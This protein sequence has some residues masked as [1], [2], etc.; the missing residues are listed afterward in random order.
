MG[1][2]IRSFPWSRTALGPVTSWPQSLKIAL[3]IMLGSRYQMFVWWGDEL[4]K[5]YNDAYISALGQRHPWALGQPASTVWSEIWG[6]IGPQTETVL[7]ENRATW[8]DRVEL[9]ME[10]NGYMEETF[11]TFSYSPL[12]ND[13]GEIG[14]VFC[15]CSEETERVLG[16]RRLATLRQLGDETIRAQNVPEACELAAKALEKNARDVSFALIYLLEPDGTT[17]RLVANT[18]NIVAGSA[19]APKRVD[20]RDPLA[21][22]AWPF[23]RALQGERVKVSELT[24]QCGPLPGGEWP[25]PTHTAMVLPL[26]RGAQEKPGGFVILGAS[27]R[28]GF[29]D[30]YQ[31]FMEL[32]AAAIA[33]AVA[34]ARAYDDERRRAESL[35]ELDRAKTAF[36][37]NVSHEF[38]TP[39]TLMLGPLED[40]L[41]R[42]GE[43]PQSAERGELRVVH[44]NGLRLLKL[45]NT[46]LDF[47]QIEAGRMQ[48]T[49]VET[50]LAVL[51]ADLASVFRSAMEKAGLNFTIDCP[52]LPEPV[53]VDPDMW[54]KIVFNLLSNALKFTLDGDV[55]LTLS[56]SPEAAVLS[57]SDTGLGI[58]PEELPNLFKRFHRIEST[59][60]RTHEGTGIGLALVHDLAKLH[61]GTV[62]VENGDGG[63]GT[64]FKVR[65]PFGKRHLPPER[66]GYERSRIH[67]ARHSEEFIEEASTWS[68]EE[69]A[70]GI[71]V[72]TDTSEHPAA[73]SPTAVRPRVLLA[74]DNADMR[75]YVARL[76]GTRYRV[77]PVADGVTALAAARRDPPDLILSDVMMPALDGFALVKELRADE[78]LKS[79]P[80]ILLSA[81]AGEEARV[82]G[83]IAGADDYVTKPFTSR[84][85]LARVATQL[86]LARVRREAALQVQRS[87]RFVEKIA[88]A[89]PDILFAYDLVEQRN[90][91]I[92]RSVEAV[93]GYS[94][95]QVQGMTNPGEQLVHPD[96][97]AARADYLAGFNQ[98]ADGAVR[99]F[100]YRLRAVNGEDRWILTRASVFARTAE[101]RP[102]E[103]I[104]VAIDITARKRTETALRESEDRYRAVLDNQTEML[105]RFHRDGTI[106]FVNG[107]Y[108]RS[109]GAGR[110]EL[111]GKNLWKFIPE[112]DHPAI[113]AMLDGLTAAAPEVQIENRFETI[114]G[115][116]WTLWTNRAVSFDST[117]RWKEA[118]STGIDITDRKQSEIRLRASEDQARA[119]FSELS[120]LYGAAPVGLAL[121]DRDLRFVR[122]NET[123][124]GI[125]GVPVA[126]T[127][128]RTIGEIVPGVADRIERAY[129]Q[130][131]ETGEP[132]KYDLEGEM[133][134]SP[135][136]RRHFLV[137]HYPLQQ[138]DGSVHGIGCV[139]LETTEQKRAEAIVR[140]SE[141]RQSFLLKL[142]DAL[143]PLTNPV[144]IQAMA[145]QVLGEHLAAS[146]V[147]YFEV[148]DTDYILARN[149]T[150]GVPPLIGA[151]PIA[152]FGARLLTTYR[153]GRTVSCCNVA[154][155]TELTPAERAAY[156]A[157]QI[158]AHIGV[159]LVKGG[160]LVAGFAV[161][162]SGPREWKRWEIALTEETAQRTWAAVERARAEAALHDSEARL[163]LATEAANIYSWEIDLAE[164]H[165]MWGTNAPTV[166]GFPANALTESVDDFVALVHPDD[167]AA[168]RQ[169]VKS[170][171]AAGK[172]FAAEF[173]LIHPQTGE[174]VWVASQAAA[175]HEAPGNAGLARYFGISQNITERKRRET[176]LAFLAEIDA[177]LARHSTAE[178]ILQTVGR[179]IGEFLRLSSCAFCEVDGARAENRLQYLWQ[180]TDPRDSVGGVCCQ[181][182]YVSDEFLRA[183]LSGERVVV[184]DT[185][186]DSRVAH[187]TAYDAIQ[188]RSF[189]TVPFLRDGARKYL[190][191]VTDSAPRQ[192]RGDELDVITELC[193][194]IFPRLERA[195]AEAALRTSEARF[196]AAAS[197]VSSLIWTNNARGEMEGE[198]PGWTGFTGQPQE[199]LQGYGWAKAVHPDDAQPTI[200]AWKR[201]VEEKRMFEFEHRLWRKDGEW[202][203]CTLR[204]VPV[205][206]EAGKICEWVGVH[207]D[208]TPRKEAEKKVRESEARLR[209]SLAACQIGAWDF[210]L[211]AHTA[212][213]SLEHDRIFGYEQLLSAWTLDDFFQ[214]ALPEYHESVRQMVAEATI[215]RTGFTCEC[216]IRRKDG[217]IRWIWFSGRHFVDE[218]G[219][220]RV[221]G[222][223][224]DI[225]ERK[226]A[227]AALREAHEL[228]TDKAAQLESLVQQR[229]TK[230]REMVGELEAFSYSIAHDMRA[231]LRSL[232]GFSDVLLTEHAGN[233]DPEAQ[234]FLR[235][236]ANSAGRMDKLIQDVLN[237]SRIVRAELPLESVD[238]EKL[239]R[240]I[241]DTYPMFLPEKVEI[242]IE[243]TFS[244]VLGNEAML[245][246][247]FSNLMGNAAKF[248][249]PGVKPRIRVWA[250]PDPQRVR[251]FIQDNGIG[252]APEQ[253]EKIF[254]I[255]QQGNK[256][257]EGTGIG[258]AIVKKAVER[259]SGQIGI[260]S[261]P[262]SGSTFWFEIQ[263]A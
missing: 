98:A 69:N 254:G 216:R 218:T 166:L 136:I 99:E 126:Q 57:V 227:E 212:Y 195:Y 94:V 121:V 132:V 104:G 261:A 27:P 56:A 115:P 32:T 122:I 19:V 226:Q 51:T 171:I 234:G 251:F 210:D 158:G 157:I 238:V 84:E 8:N 203:E 58:A 52:P 230:L 160:E 113:R 211:T 148:R 242:A 221:A 62:A 202:R 85:L 11:F 119:Q 75:D 127:L 2:R 6:T 130:V 175:V 151:F 257:Y 66:I 103:I 244:P 116:R 61:G 213:R 17:V 208:I 89:S 250:E 39:I 256:G 144:A 41:A 241:V 141:A 263:R 40:L 77:Q 229:T 260:Q 180:R 54:E 108:E 107:S 5:F 31:G 42:A 16:E 219:H 3:R 143:R 29:D 201:A 217:A 209:F 147:A 172:N 105:C 156:A 162:S 183:T 28:R 177:D 185:W 220:A 125:N 133:P 100:E 155:D 110:G 248:V 79:I 224:Q 117:G 259:M 22:C 139:V 204:A 239:L 154:A 114:D 24:T 70:P 192:W 53:F 181:A 46:L 228:L 73:E 197:A 135:G 83:V 243:G 60:G 87:Q 97:R 206:D 30:S 199:E 92:N 68:S 111:L 174:V 123:L 47:S 164:R 198:Q 176:N 81:R 255:F 145:S 187:P 140:E 21:R 247:I 102:C 189:V 37:S 59:R 153:A 233:L 109:R 106:L 184:S 240:D 101:G 191:A 150:H 188:A 129:R 95:E 190:L 34:N 120:A 173:R 118:Q 149:Y 15:A 167:L 49:Y 12:P 20:F 134:S 93:L 112:E 80:I 10:R 231:P 163:R 78:Q 26:A 124:A 7:R 246:Q 50:D 258:L 131:L 137:Y 168:A 196:R 55:A 65:L 45:V 193:N 225:T 38:R 237:Y 236:I 146:R 200:D 82:E 170:A 4:T 165:L 161:H 13:D 74:D 249:K 64:T 36:F 9:L 223:T 179:S 63:R 44:R 232:Q 207:T 88:H 35:A 43:P 252:I 96:D 91:Y 67:R 18:S 159:P 33:S 14:G 222:V 86:E 215:A 245:T 169:S 182:D 71:T 142:G 128:G 214:H 72:A 1:K 205:F 178:T 25:E 48:A 138:A 90:V 194:R 186:T 253:H 76:L 152:S 23:K 262:G 235:R